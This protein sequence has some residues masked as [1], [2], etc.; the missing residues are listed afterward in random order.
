LPEIALPP[1]PHPGGGQVGAS[2]SGAYGSLGHGRADYNDA[3]IMREMHRSGFAS[4]A[5][6]QMSPAPPFDYGGMR[7]PDNYPASWSKPANGFMASADV[8]TRAPTS[9][10]PGASQQ[11]GDAYAGYDP[12]AWAGL[13]PQLLEGASSVDVREG[14]LVSERLIETD[15]QIIAGVPREM[16][17]SANPRDREDVRMVMDRLA[18]GGVAISGVRPIY[19][20]EKIVEVPHVITREYDKHVPK[21]EIIERLIEVPITE[22]R[23]KTIKL[24]PQVQYQE[25]IVE[26]PEVVI[27]ERVIHVPRREVQERLI[28]VPKVRYVERIEYEDIIEYREVPVDRIVEVPEIEYRVREVEQLVPQTYIQEYY[29]DRYREVPVTQIQEVERIEHVPVVVPPG[30]QAPQ[31]A[32]Y[33]PSAATYTA[34]APMPAPMA[35]AAPVYMR[36][37]QAAPMQMQSM[38]AFDAMDRNHDGMLTREEYNQAQYAPSAAAYTT[39]APMPA[40]MAV[41]AP[42]YMMAS[43][44]APMQMQSMSAFD[45][46]DRN[47][48]GMLTREE[49]N[50]AMFAGPPMTSMGGPPT[51]PM[52][53]Y[54]SS[55]AMPAAAATVAQASA[56]LAASMPMQMPAQS[57]ASLPANT[58]QFLVPRGTFASRPAASMTGMVPAAS[59]PPMPA[60]QTSYLAVGPGP[61]ISG[62]HC[63]SGTFV[64]TPPGSR[65]GS[66]AIPTTNQAAASMSMSMPGQLA[67]GSSMYYGGHNPFESFPGVDQ[68][69]LPQYYSSMPP[70]GSGNPYMSSGFAGQA[71]QPQSM[72]AFDALD[73]NHDGMLTRDEFNQAVRAAA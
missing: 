28:E 21:P 32:Q 8:S 6:H 59:V 72:S 15:Q 61:S 73:R 4:T 67:H 9:W 16:F 63:G 37:S 52:P 44:A 46:M 69:P 68:P 70:M 57:M 38:S 65:Y 47:H 22:I 42:V 40:P 27:E 17:S 71:R 41:A 12:G 20:V 14:R 56:F 10:H 2:M 1:F 7:Q 50:Q 43:Q 48:D 51:P 45:A 26:V 30:Y 24:P 19:M 36:A 35:V 39:P 13:P 11:G 29:V 53:L 34:P 23:T 55:H 66:A 58:Q 49:Y 25:M 5:P 3:D 54:G 60:R 62:M 31:M 33:A 18:E 64:P